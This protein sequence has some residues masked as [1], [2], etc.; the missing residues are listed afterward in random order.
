MDQQNMR[1]RQ[2]WLSGVVLLAVVVAL[3][4]WAPTR[5]QAQNYSF[6]IP[7]MQM[8]VFVQDDASARIVYD[9]TF[10]NAPSASPIDIVDIGTPHDDYD[11]SNMSA[12]INGTPLNTIR[13]S[14]YIDTGVEIP[15]GSNAIA[16]GEQATLNFEFTMP[17]MVY[18]DT[19][20]GDYA[21]LQITPT[22]FDSSLVNGTT[23]L[24]I[25]VHMLPGIEPDEVLF[26]DVPFDNKAIFDD[27]VVVVW[28]EPDWRA[29][30]PYRVGVSFPE[31]GISGVIRMN[32]FQLAVKWVEDNPPVR[33]FLTGALVVL[34]GIVFFRFTGNTG[35]SVF[36][37]V[38]GILG[39][40]AYSAPA[41]L[42]LSFLPMPLLIFFNERHLRTR[43]NKYLPPIAQVEGGGIKRGLT[44][45]EAAVILEQPINKVLTLVIF[46]LLK[47]GVLRQVKDDPL[48]V[49][50]AEAFRTGSIASTKDRKSH[51][52]KAAQEAGTILHTYEHGFLDLIERRP[53]SPLKDIDFGTPMKELIA[54]AAARV[55]GFDLSD[56]Q[57]YYR[58]ITRR[59]LKEAS[60]IQ[61]IEQR[62]KRLDRNL[63]WVLMN[64]DFGGVFDAPRYGYRYRPMWTRPIFIGGLGGSGGGGGGG[65]PSGGGPSV[66]GSTSFSDVAAS[67]AGWT[68]NTMGNMADAIAPGSLQ[69]PDVSGGVVDL[70]GADKVTADFFEALAESSAK[71]GGGGGGGCACAG[72]ACACACAGGGR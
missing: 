24:Q 9:I 57:D 45:P 48:Q 58:S 49:E 14:E 56:T 19:T 51:R 1:T 3:L 46:G 22:W 59:A 26:Q 68:E 37:V 62:E 30:G 72:C 71:G 39:F 25:A 10:Q 65:A 63:E 42:L 7:R 53:D 70:S 50:V 16:P 20:Q 64:D 5:A 18:G 54:H 12:S 29:T 4:A 2:A 69:A 41:L 33:L 27:H 40:L 21:S 11:T 61:D 43:R 8:E 67:F 32:A 35:C 60:E 55:K 23:Q 66:G 15:L 28:E 6:S 17:D 47:K 13:P 44:A 38:A 36:V 31:R 52:L 34:L